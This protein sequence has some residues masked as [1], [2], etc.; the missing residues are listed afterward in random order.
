MPSERLAAQRTY[1]GSAEELLVALNLDAEWPTRKRAT[2][3]QRARRRKNPSGERNAAAHDVIAALAP[4]LNP[5]Q[6][7]Q[8]LLDDTPHEPRP[9][10]RPGETR[11]QEV[12]SA[13]T[14][15]T[16]TGRLGTGEAFKLKVSRSR[17][18]RRA[19]GSYK[20]D[21]EGESVWVAGRLTDSWWTHVEVRLR[22]P[23]A[24]AQG[25]NRDELLWLAGLPPWTKKT[26]LELQEDTLVLSSQCS[27]VATP[28]DLAEW[29]APALVTFATR[30]KAPVPE[31][32][33]L[34]PDTVGLFQNLVLA[35]LVDGHLDLSEVRFLSSRAQ[36]L[37]LST[38]Q[39][40]RLASEVTSGQVSEFCRPEDPVACRVAFRQAVEGLHAD[41]ALE[42]REQRLIRFLGRGLGVNQG[43]LAQ[44]LGEVPPGPD[45]AFLRRSQPG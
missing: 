23:L 31:H 42:E 5:A 32:E 10:N 43:D 33:E 36:W 9:P 13:R 28:E 19:P 45:W 1:S 4:H 15:I 37:G 2:L 41:G 21:G 40:Q 26:T 3:A 14:R 39:A 17:H 8:L 16:L 44:A 18:S 11:P 24:V 35:V 25:V 12:K 29:I 38:G 20:T 7:L 27:G 22:L 30:R 6:P 34:D